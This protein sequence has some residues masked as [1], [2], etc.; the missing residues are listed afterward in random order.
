M[1]R[2]AVLGTLLLASI[3]SAQEAPL[4]WTATKYFQYNIENITYDKTAGTVK[5][6]FS[7]SNPSDPTKPFWNIKTDA[8]FTAGGRSS[9]L[10]ID[11]GWDTADYTNTGSNG[12]SLNPV[13]RPAA[14]GPGAALPVSVNAL[15][16]SVACTGATDCPGIASV[17]GRYY[18]T[19]KIVPLSFNGLILNSA[20]AAIEGHPACATTLS[21]CPPAVLINNVLT[22]G[23]V[24]V[25]SVVKY[26]SLTGGTAVARRQVVDINKCKG[27][28]D[29][30]LHNGK[31]IPR[32]SLHGANRNEEPQLCVVCHNPNQTDIPYRTSG[33]EVSVDFKR[34]VHSIHAG[35]FRTT[36]YSVVGFQGT[37][38]DFSAVRFPKELRNCVLCHID[39]NGKGT[40]ELPIK[41]TLGTTIATGTV[42][43]SGFV[44]VDPNNDLKISPTAA[45]CSG[46]HD[47]AEVQSHMIRTGG[48]SFGVRQADLKVERCASC[49]GPG[50]EE[51]V[52]R[53]HEIGRS[54]T[55]S[56]R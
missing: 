47:K 10:S 46:C 6:I 12:G 16:A 14:G 36:P 40:F 32:L 51:D 7:V 53:A 5:V 23:N 18:V 42:Q 8:P 41:T 11:V 24:P 9:R 31:V 50:K 49:H 34:M 52:R 1:N 35:G 20:V 56:D 48:A 28:H 15:T 29:D 55:R 26:F 33:A 3:A 54:G 25:K 45:T 21:Y 27:C 38:Y 44:D 17:T 39:A 13:V 2:L 30:A 43:G 19:T 37:V 4:V 22:P